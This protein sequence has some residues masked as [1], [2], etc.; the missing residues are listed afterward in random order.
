MVDSGTHAMTTSAKLKR[1]RQLGRA[2][3]MGGTLTV[4]ETLD[5]PSPFPTYDLQRRLLTFANREESDT[6]RS[7]TFHK[8][9]SYTHDIPSHRHIIEE[10]GITACDFKAD[11]NHDLIVYQEVG[12]EPQ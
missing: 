5:I 2:W 8:F 10:L 3:A 6:F 9:Q 4:R 11:S 7:V 1:L 12:S